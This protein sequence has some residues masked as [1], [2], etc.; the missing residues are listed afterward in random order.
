LPISLKNLIS[1]EFENENKN[2]IITVP[3]NLC[4]F[5]KFNE[6]SIDKINI[7]NES[8]LMTKFKSK[9]SLD[10]EF[11]PIFEKTIEKALKI[12]NLFNLFSSNNSKH[13]L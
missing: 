4:Q 12:L 6:K 9:D 7:I 1:I 11:V 10:I 13:N 3:G 8:K 5:Y 2:L